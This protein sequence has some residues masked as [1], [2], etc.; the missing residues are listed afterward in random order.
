MRPVPHKNLSHTMLVGERKCYSS[1][2]GRGGMSVCQWRVSQ[3][4]K[5]TFTI[6]HRGFHFPQTEALIL[7]STVGNFIHTLKMRKKT[8]ARTFHTTFVVHLALGLHK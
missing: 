7:V 5:G 1:G 2:G 4:V 8:C 6:N 3:D